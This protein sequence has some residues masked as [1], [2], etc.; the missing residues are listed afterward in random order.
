MSWS[1]GLRNR[2]PIIIRIC[3]DR[4]KFYCFFHILLFPFSIVVCMVLCT[5]LLNFVYYDF[6]STY[7]D[8]LCCSMYCLCVNVYCTNGIC[9]K[10]IK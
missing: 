9:Y 10:Y 6:R 3:R 7:C 4:M 5:L 8:S 1:D 2:V